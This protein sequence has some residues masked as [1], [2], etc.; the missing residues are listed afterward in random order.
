MSLGQGNILVQSLPLPGGGPP[1]PANAAENGLSVDPVTGRIVLGDDTGGVLAQLLSDREIQMDGFSF[2]LKQTIPGP[3]QSNLLVV[4]PTGGVYSLGDFDGFAN[5]TVVEINDSGQYAQIR[6]AGIDALNM[7][8]VNRLYR[9]GDGSLSGNPV[10][11]NIDGVNNT[12]DFAQDADKGFDI[13]FNNRL[14]RFG[15][16]A[17]VGSGTRIEIDDML[18]N[19]TIINDGKTTIQNNTFFRSLEFDFLNGLYYAGDIDNS[20]NN[21]Y[22]LIDANTERYEMYNSGLR[23][24]FF[25]LLNFEYIIGNNTASGFGNLTINNSGGNPRLLFKDFNGSF[26][27]LNFGTSNYKMGDIDGLTNNTFVEVDDAAELVYI[28]A[29]NGLGI[30]STNGRLLKTF[31]ALSNGA[32]AGA[33]T[34]TNAPT[35]GD[36]S[37]WI[38]LDDNGTTR[39]IPTWT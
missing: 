29:N 5:S 18:Q 14:Y 7:D 21:I 34:L 30:A 23:H 3:L 26:L 37:K 9:F 35:A 13:D 10:N 24:I 6:G 27:D 15:D 22:W 12:V 31:Q 28:S 38:P 19:Q 8:F 33:G 2:R 39:Y 11:L 36:P 32:G 25:D 20:I 1:F 17:P 4:D 16:I